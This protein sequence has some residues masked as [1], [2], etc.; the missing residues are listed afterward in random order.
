MAKRNLPVSTPATGLFQFLNI[1]NFGLFQTAC[2]AI[3]LRIFIVFREHLP[4]YVFTSEKQSF[5][6]CQL[7]SIRNT[8]DLMTNYSSGKTIKHTIAN[9]PGAGRVRHNKNTIK[10]VVF[11][12]LPM[13]R[14]FGIA[15]NTINL[16]VWR[17]GAARVP[18]GCGIIRSKYNGLAVGVRP[19]AGR[20]SVQ[21][22]LRA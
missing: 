7:F 2:A 16:M 22:C 9:R 15:E 13:R 5:S 19:G 8:C 12:H 6:A 3:W 20:T 4:G 11:L 14:L 10:P 21:S 18:P 1:H 17:S